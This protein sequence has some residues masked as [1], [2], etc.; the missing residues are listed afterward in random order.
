[1]KIRIYTPKEDKSVDY[2]GFYYRKLLIISKN[3]IKYNLKIGNLRYSNVDL[4]DNLDDALVLIHNCGRAYLLNFE[5]KSDMGLIRAIVEEVIYELNE[6][7]YDLE[8][9]IFVFLEEGQKID[10]SNLKSE[11]E[12]KFRLV[13]VLH[14]DNSPIEPTAREKK[15]T[16]IEF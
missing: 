6:P 13:D 8:D 10:L 9:P 2:C 12:S 5:D 3:E 11:L 4:P 14:E 7:F 16:R 15:I 1:M